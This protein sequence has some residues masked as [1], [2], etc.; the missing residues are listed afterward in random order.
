L[1][2]QMD[3][4]GQWSFDK[5]L[6]RSTFGSNPFQRIQRIL[7]AGPAVSNNSLLAIVRSFGPQDDELLATQTVR[8]T[9]RFAAE[10]S[11]ASGQAAD[12]EVKTTQKFCVLLLQQISLVP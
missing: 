3:G 5:Q 11:G 7:Q 2:V 1:W 8:E 9:L 6:T 10:L 12:V 4:S